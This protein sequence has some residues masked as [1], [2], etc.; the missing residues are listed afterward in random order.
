MVSSVMRSISKENGLLG[1]FKKNR[2]EEKET[3]ALAKL[4]GHAVPRPHSSAGGLIPLWDLFQD[5]SSGLGVIVLKDGSY[6]CCFELDGVHVSGFDEVRLVSL[7]NHFT[8]FLNGIDTS[9]QLTVICHN[10][11]KREYFS[12]HPVEAIND[13]F[14]QYVAKAVEN[15]EAFLLSK[16]FIPELK[17]YVTFCY[18]PPKEKPAHQNWV[19]RTV[20]S[21]VDAFTSQASRQTVGAHGRN[22]TTLIQRAH[23]YVAQLGSCGMS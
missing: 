11:S 2:T 7:M 3:G 13:E 5:N 16:N 19:E 12:R 21:I 14:L 9:V 20:T 18:R 15:D 17:F 8:G 23:G 1:V 4:P 22:V 10:I 6:R